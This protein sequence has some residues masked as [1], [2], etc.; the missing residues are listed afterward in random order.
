[1]AT[2]KQGYHNAAGKRLPSVTTILSRFK[3][4]GALIKWAYR[5]GREHEALAAKGLDAPSDLYAKDASTAKA[6]L[7][8]TIAHDMIEQHVL[9]KHGVVPSVPVIGEVREKYP[10]VEIDIWNRALNSYE[11]FVEWFALTRIEVTHTEM[12]LT[13]ETY[14]FG[15][16]PDAVGTDSKGRVVLIDWKTSNGV[17]PDYLYQL[18]AYGLLLEECMPELKPQGFHLLR[19]AKETADFSHH[20]WS[21]LDEQA[22]GF[23]LMRELYEIDAT[24]KKRAR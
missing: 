17:Y 21:E 15:G 2:P 12:Q 6:A 19:V 10:D 5:Q 11:Q 13:S 24:T 8:G 14:G 3:D 23:L 22:R 9:G 1:M 7:A 16:T 18:A 20:F 4:S